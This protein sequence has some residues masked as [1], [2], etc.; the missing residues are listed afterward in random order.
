MTLSP[1][2]DSAIVLDIGTAS[3][4]AA[5]ARAGLMARVLTNDPLP[6]VVDVVAAFATVTVFYNLSDIEDF[7]KFCQQV[8]KRLSQIPI[9]P[10]GVA[11]ATVEIPICY[12][13][14]F[15][16]DQIEIAEANGHNVDEVIALHAAGEY[17]V[18][19]VGFAPGF[20]YLGGLDRRIHCPRRATPRTHVP[21]G[22]VG[23]GGTLTAA[24]PFDSPGGW[25]LVGRTPLT[26]FDPAREIPSLLKTG[27]AVRFRP[28]SMEEFS[29]WK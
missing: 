19:A 10:V 26:L 18:Q 5:C 28:I 7:T 24:Y 3:D 29:K 11:N 9:T 2:G 12:A 13:K 6:G 27:N 23:I 8:Q 16:P 22:S 17:V 20:A 15:G 25:N 21:A 1:L 4:Q 14:E